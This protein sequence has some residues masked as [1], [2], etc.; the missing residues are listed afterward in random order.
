MLDDEQA[1]AIAISLQ[2]AGAL[3]AGIEEAAERALSTLSRTMPG[4]LARRVESLSL[5]AA[6]PSHRKNLETD[7][8]TLLHIGQ[9]IRFT[10]ELRFD[11]AAP[12]QPV[13]ASNPPPVRVVEPYHLLLHAGRWYLIGYSTERQDWRIY[14]VDR[15]SP[16]APNGRRFTPR[17]LPGGD[18]GRFLSARFKGS[19]GAD[20]WPCW[21][22]AVLRAPVAEV[23]PYIADGTVEP[24][25]DER[26]RVRLG[27]W[28]YRSL[29]AAIGRFDAD[30]EEVEPPEL[31]QAFSDL[32]RRFAAAG[33]LAAPR[34]PR[35]P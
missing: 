35:P 12:D 26:C 33:D 32:A 24:L 19:S 11:Y 20:T 21:G 23:A 5:A 18:P 31:A 17:Q 14:R 29:A 7:P 2:T 10:E 6:T 4:H 8:K 9:A 3:G 15:I 28:S 25:D 34:A 22:E 30:V 27:S 1:V 16:R 13:D